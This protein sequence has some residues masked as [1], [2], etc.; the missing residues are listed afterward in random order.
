M[1][2]LDPILARFR[3]QL[4]RRPYC[5]DDLSAGLVI[6][7]RGQAARY[8]YIQPNPPGLISWLVFDVDRP[9]AVLSW[10]DA[11]LPPP[12]LTVMNLDNGHAHLLYAL[13]IPVCASPAARSHPLRY[14]A[15]VE[16]AYVARLAADPGYSQLI[17]KNPLRGDCWQVQ[18]F[19]TG[20]YPLR[21]LAHWVDLSQPTRR[22]EAAAQG[23]GRNCALFDQLRV[24]AYRHVLEYHAMS[25]YTA[26]A[27]DVLGKAESFN[28][29]RVPLP[30]SEIRATAKSVSRYCWQRFTPEA[31]RD[32]IARTHTPE[33]QAQRGRQ[34]GIASGR[35]R[36]QE[37]ERRRLLA[38]EMKRQGKSFEEIAKNLE[39]SVYRAKKYIY[40]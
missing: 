22:P 24:W 20:L 12:S 5:T 27:V 9:Y 7:S 23:L 3:K 31:L 21:D 6:R 18:V 40:E 15:A 17:T 34:G 2:R 26:W 35:V 32:L 37:A 29:F 13:A 1:H 30:F 39:I 8:R 33:L 11:N 16:A 14:A 10:E 28:T 36:L 19:H 25:S 4:P 38:C